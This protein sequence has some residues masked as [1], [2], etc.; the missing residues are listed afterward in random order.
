MCEPASIQYL[1]EVTIGYIPWSS[2]CVSSIITQRE[3]CLATVLQIPHWNHWYFGKQQQHLYYMLG[4]SAPLIT[5]CE[6]NQTVIIF[7]VVHQSDFV[8]K[9]YSKKWWNPALMVL[10]WYKLPS[11]WSRIF[12]RKKLIRIYLLKYYMGNS[13]SLTNFSFHKYLTFHAILNLNDVISL[14]FI[15]SVCTIT[16]PHHFDLYLSALDLLKF[17]W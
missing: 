12:F 7:K 8:A 6:A 11:R 14:D 5:D 13:T 3:P 17:L 2:G 4:L 15:D 10:H 9:R 16:C 1:G